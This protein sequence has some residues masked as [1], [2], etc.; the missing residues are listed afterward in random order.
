MWKRW[1]RRIFIICGTL[2]NVSRV[3]RVYTF[4]SAYKGKKINVRHTFIHIPSPLIPCY[5]CGS[6]ECNTKTNWIYR[7]QRMCTVS[8][9]AKFQPQI[10]PKSQRFPSLSQTYCSVSYLVKPANIRSLLQRPFYPPVLWMSWNSLSV[11]SPHLLL[12]HCRRFLFLFPRPFSFFSTSSLWLI[13]YIISDVSTLVWGCHHAF[14][15]MPQRQIPANLLYRELTLFRSS[16]SFRFQLSHW[17]MR[18]RRATS[19]NVNRETPEPTSWSM[20]ASSA[21]HTDR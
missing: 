15:L 1:R 20:N 3:R 14:V 2:K 16:H 5:C 9:S 10:L 19:W 8:S 7:L 17:L 13:D 11:S 4:R 18:Q 21:W 12:C 6:E